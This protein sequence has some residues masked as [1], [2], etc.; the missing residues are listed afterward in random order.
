MKNKYSVILADPPWQYDNAGSRG[1]AELIYPTMSIKE[2]CAL[3]VAGMAQD[4]AV[5]LLWTTWSQ[6]TEAM[7]LI[8]AWGFKYVTGF[9]WIKVT[10]VSPNLWGQIEVSVPY[11]IGFWARGASEPLLIARRGKVK[12]P[13]NG[14]IGL[15]SPNLYHSRKPE[16]IYHYAETLSGPYLE[17]FAR[18]TRPGWDS[19]GNQIESTPDVRRVLSGE[20]TAVL[21]A[22]LL[23][24]GVRE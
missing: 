20:D 12:A 10:D 5:L 16:S 14:F 15:L 24:Q 7:Q 9:P 22:E 13:P 3:P 6:M 17:L 8:S 21:R 19:W 23:A 2:L 1:A 11:G 4:N 18:R